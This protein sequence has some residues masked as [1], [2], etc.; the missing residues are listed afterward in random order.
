VLVAP[1]A[2]DPALESLLDELAAAA[3]L[4][5]EARSMLTAA[6]LTADLS[7]VVA[8]PPDPGLAELAAAAPQTTFLGVGIPDL[9]PAA[10]LSVIGAPGADER[11][12][13]AGYIAAAVT[14]EWRVGVI[15]VSD[16]TEGIA[17]RQGYLNGAIFFCGLCKQLYPPFFSYP[18]Y[19]EMPAAS[20][21]A[22]WQAAADVLIGKAV[23]TVYVVPGAG[24][25]DLLIYLGEAGINL[26]GE[27]TPPNAVEEH[28]IASIQADFLPAVRQIWPLLL[29]GKGGET[30]PLPLA[31]SNINAT[32]FSPGRQRLTA[33]MMQDLSSGMI[34]TGV[35]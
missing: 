21:A 18:L 5:F 4:R 35:K 16:T 25:D 28:W 14:S 17:A 34:D 2:T 3:G 6:Q 31:L 30:L 11:G 7:I 26:I 20:S 22:E 32:L 27:G 19:V 12:F 9:R 23:K 13:L 1:P 15:G 8:L 33:E 29:E 10:N 24:N